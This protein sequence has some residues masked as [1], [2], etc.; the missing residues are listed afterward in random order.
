MLLLF[1][2]PSLPR[3]CEHTGSR[4]SVSFGGLGTE[5]TSLKMPV[6]VGVG[7]WGAEVRRDDSGDWGIE[8]GR[9]GGYFRN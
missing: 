9:G 1:F 6:R 3:D 2:A 5:S 4:F 8:G 7:G